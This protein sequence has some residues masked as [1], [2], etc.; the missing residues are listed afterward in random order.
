MVEV[1]VVG[2]TGQIGA[3]TVARLRERGHSAAAASPSTGVDLVTGRGLDAVLAGASVVIDVSK[4]HAGDPASV[5]EFFTTGTANLMRAERAHG[6]RHHLGLTIVG[7]GRPHDIP[8]YRAKT[9]GE[10]TVRDSGVPWSLVHATQFF[11][12]APAIAAMADADGAITLPDVDV[13]PAAGADVADVM[14]EL[15][16]A[17]PLQADIEIAGPERMPLAGFVSRALRARHDDRDVRS[18]PEG[19]YFGGRPAAETL[20]PDAGARILPTRFQD[21]LLTSSAEGGRS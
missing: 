1:I 2:G 11:E 15:A 10:R 20:L 13:Q 12:F 8:F 16:L 17:A 3:K 5:Q 21:W 9:L 7:S 19:R 14:V 18:G 4:P 6:I